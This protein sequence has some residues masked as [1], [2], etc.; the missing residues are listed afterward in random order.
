MHAEWQNSRLWKKE[1]ISGFRHSFTNMAHD[2]LGEN[3]KYVSL[4]QQRNPRCSSSGDLSIP[5][6]LTEKYKLFRGANA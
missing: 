5:L 3:F 1:D 2:Y 4:V 6:P